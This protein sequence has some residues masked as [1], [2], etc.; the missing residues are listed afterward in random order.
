ME[1]LNDVGMNSAPLD[2]YKVYIE[3]VRLN[4][5]YSESK[6][7]CPQMKTYKIQVSRS[8]SIQVLYFSLK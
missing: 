5:V 2:Q 1:W 7:K 3:S 4:E 6:S 8:S